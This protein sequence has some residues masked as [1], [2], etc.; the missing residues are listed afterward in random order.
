M[1]MVGRCNLLLALAATILMVGVLSFACGGGGDT[2]TVY[3]GRS[4]SLVQP[5]LD[6]FEEETGISVRVNYASTSQITATILEEGD[7]SPADVVF[8]QD[9]G[10]LGVLSSEGMLASLP[11]DI[12][13]MVDERYRAGNGDWVGASGRA[14]TVVYNTANIDP[15]ADLPDSISGFTDPVWKGRIG[16][17]PQNASFQT[18]LTGM[19]VMLGDDETR[20]WLEGIQANEPRAYPN[21]TTTVQ[22]AAN[23]EIDVGFVNHYYLHRFLESEGEG[24]GAR[25]HYIGNGDP[26][27]LLLT[28]GAGIMRTSDNMEQGERFIRFLL[29]PATQEYFASETFEYPLSGE[30]PDQEALLPLD[31]LD[32]PDIDLSD[33]SDAQGT[34]DILRET[35]IL[36]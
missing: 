22:A 20:N 10:F 8:L 14:R 6:R 33:L 25:N 26:G 16:W 11:S 27:A 3:S 5:V 2:I 1:N 29:S 32:P 30:L 34:L 19:R 9:P 12:L 36:P 17:P 13:N 35:G 28:A 31:L 4:E 23:G 24:F 7:G 21:N 18:F 15:D